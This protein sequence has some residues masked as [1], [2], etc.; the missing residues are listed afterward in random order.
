MF[1][2]GIVTVAASGAGIFVLLLFCKFVLLFIS[3]SITGVRNNLVVMYCYG[4][5]FA[6]VGVQ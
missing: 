4:I 1:G 2:A 3:F 5:V 6:L